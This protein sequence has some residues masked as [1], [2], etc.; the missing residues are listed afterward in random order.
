MVVE[1]SSQY[2]G[3]EWA[4]QKASTKRHERFHQRGERAAAR[5]ERG[6]NGRRIIS[7]DHEVVHLQEIAAGDADDRPDL[8]F[9]A[10]LTH[11]LSRLDATAGFFAS[12]ASVSCTLSRAPIQCELTLRRIV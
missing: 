9:A 10:G 8:R 3:S 6:G 12:A 2:D 1:I 4:H 5:E 11:E 7:E